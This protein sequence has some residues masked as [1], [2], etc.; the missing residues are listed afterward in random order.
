MNDENFDAEKLL[1]YFVTAN[2][3]IHKKINKNDIVLVIGNTGSG[4]I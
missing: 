1:G 2:E 3:R 4:K